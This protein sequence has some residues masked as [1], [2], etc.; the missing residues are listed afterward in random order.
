MSARL[1][2]L[3]KA[4]LPIDWSVSGNDSSVNPV[5]PSKQ[6]SPTVVTDLGIDRLE[7]PLHKKNACDPS[8]TIELGRLTLLRSEQPLRA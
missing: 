5:Q 2:Q 8:V 1:T 3:L 6:F 4:S 7:S